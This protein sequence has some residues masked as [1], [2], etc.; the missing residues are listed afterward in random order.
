MITIKLPH[1]G[2]LQEPIMT[3]VETG[4]ATVR[5]GDRVNIE[6]LPG[7]YEVKD[8]WEGHVSRIPAPLVELHYDRACRTWSGLMLFLSMAH[9]HAKVMSG[10]HVLVLVAEKKTGIVAVGGSAAGRILR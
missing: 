3:L 8:I 7:G 6:G 1:L 9:G 10:V 2:E 5:V 4:P